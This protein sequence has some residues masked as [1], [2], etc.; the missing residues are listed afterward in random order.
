K[1]FRDNYLDLAFDLSKVLF[2]TTANTLDTVP[3]PLLDRM[4]ILRLAGYSEEEKVEIARRYL[5]PRQVHEAGLTTEQLRLTDEAL[6]RVIRGFT[7]EAGVRSLERALGRL[8]RKV[9]RRIADGETAGMEIRPE[10][11]ANLLGPERFYQERSRRHLQPGVV[12]GLAWTE[13]G[14]EVLYV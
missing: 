5:I 13:A 7:R 14:G 10:D 6:H 1:T 11:L 2:I 4:E 8:A 3:Q 9:A 12:A